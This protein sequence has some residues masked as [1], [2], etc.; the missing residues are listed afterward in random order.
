MAFLDNSGD[1]LLD[2]VLTDAGR[3][4]MAEGT[5][6]IT[7]FA[8]ADDEIDYGL[9]NVNDL[10]GS[11]YY[12]LDILSTPILE[13]FTDNA[14]GLKSKLM[15]I[16]RTDLEYLPVIKLFERTSAGSIRNANLNCF[17]VAANERTLDALSIVDG[18][19][20]K[21]AQ[22][23]LYGT[24]T[25]IVM[26]Q[27]IDN[28]AKTPGT[29][30]D[31]SLRETQYIIEIDNRLGTIRQ[32]DDTNIVLSP[33]YIDD[34]DIASY[35]RTEDNTRFVLSEVAAFDAGVT[36]ENRHPNYTSIQGQFGTRLQF[37]INPSDRLKDADD[38]FERIGGTFDPYAVLGGGYQSNTI[39]YIDATVRVIGATTGYRLDIPVRFAKLQEQ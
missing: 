7:K 38:L 11:A 37:S 31:S 19:E 33:A 14:A 13:A 25:K 23:V 26:D 36:A 24:S 6:R 5:F 20:N 12:D 29:A 18:S 16:T 4:R 1:I 15:S 8:L 21:R 2:A 32:A 17:I 10:R 27:G 34:D 3:K 30:I 9:Y 35:I 28:E 39:L 22:G